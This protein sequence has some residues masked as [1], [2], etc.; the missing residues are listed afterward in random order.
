MEEKSRGRS[1]DIRPFAEL[2]ADHLRD[3]RAD[4]SFSKAFCKARGNIPPDMDLGK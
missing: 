1:Q 3:A 4:D 2:I